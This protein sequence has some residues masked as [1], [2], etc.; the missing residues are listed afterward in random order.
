MRSLSISAIT[1]QIQ[2]S[3]FYI[4]RFCTDTVTI[5]QSAIQHRP[6]NRIDFRNLLHRISTDTDTQDHDQ[7]QNGNYLARQLLLLDKEIVYLEYEGFK[8]FLLKKM[9]LNKK[10]QR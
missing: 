2:S 3:L 6:S 7:Y 4:N 5:A 10:A 8:P 9:H 1:K